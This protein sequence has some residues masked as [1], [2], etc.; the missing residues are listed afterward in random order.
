MI[1][2]P[3]S[4]GELLDKVVILE[5]KVERVRD[6]EKRRNCIKE[7]ALLQKIIETN[8]FIFPEE[9]SAL[10]KV[11]ERLWDIEDLMR[12]KEKQQCFD[13][14]F[15]KAARD[16]Y[17]ANDERAALKRLLNVRSGSDITEEKEYPTYR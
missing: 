1:Y 11:N 4:I 2:V 15:I 14:E 16:E 6:S 10:K 9:R 12:R 17:R 3:V 8:N 13:E 5:I 7:Y